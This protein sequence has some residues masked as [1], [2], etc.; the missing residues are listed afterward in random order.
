MSRTLTRQEASDAVSKLGWRYMLGTLRTSMPVQT[1]VQ[2]SELAA[3]AIT[4]CGNDADEHLRVELRPDQ[5][6]LT[7]QSM[8][9]ATVTESD[10][11][12]ASLI[13]AAVGQG[14]PAAR[15][16]QLLEIAI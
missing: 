14:E 8:P 4:A 9:E 2:A 11:E 5:V 12:L 7:L 13:T 15:A 6:I 10:V 1:L 16:V 3:T